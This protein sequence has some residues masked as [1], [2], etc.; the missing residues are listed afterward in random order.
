MPIPPPTPIAAP[1]P[2][3]ICMGARASPMPMP[4]PG[5]R[6]ALWLRCISACSSFFARAQYGMTHCWPGSVWQCL[7]WM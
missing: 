1:P 6:A 3:I 5:P 2:G 7:A 4:M